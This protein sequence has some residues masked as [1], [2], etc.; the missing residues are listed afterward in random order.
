MTR[1]GADPE[2]RFF[3]I[4]VMK[5][6]GTTFVRQLQE[7]FP[8]EAVYPSRAVD[9]IGADDFDA[10]IRIPRLLALPPERR[11]QVRAYTG[12]FPFYVV[13]A[14][15][16]SLTTLTVLREPI[17]RTVSVLKHFKRVEERFRPCSLETIYEDRQI[18]RFFVENH[19]TKVFSLAA[20]DDETAINCGLTIDDAR[21]ER[22]RAN[23][24]RVDVLGLTEAYDD[25]VLDVQ[26]R[27]GWWADGVDRSARINVSAEDW[28]V[29]PAFRER[30]AAEN[31]YDVALYEYARELLRSG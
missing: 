24:A 26:R 18:F 19:Q 27:F 31:A 6:A 20:D 22:A 8:A 10:Y 9:W 4:H 1:P 14:L 25:F 13:D 30:I 15:D 28:D 3:F 29:A 16:P 5:T 21:Y 17:A 2:A 23:L 12:H 7:E 11:A